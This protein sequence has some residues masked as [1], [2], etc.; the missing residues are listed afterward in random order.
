MSEQV[1][2]RIGRYY[3]C[4]RCKDRLLVDKKTILKEIHYFCIHCGFYHKEV[5]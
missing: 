4:P 5:K 3:F 2:K 1:I